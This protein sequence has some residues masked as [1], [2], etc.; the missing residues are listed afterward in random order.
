MSTALMKMY[1]SFAGIIFMFVSVALI[2]FSRSKLK[3]G[4]LRI[5]L[6]FIAWV[7]MILAGIIIFFI[8]FSGPVPE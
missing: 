7:L 4:I 3:P 8:V 6:S 1:V 5:V 2:M